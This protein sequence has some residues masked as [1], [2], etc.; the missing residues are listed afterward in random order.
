[1][2]RNHKIK[3]K[4]NTIILHIYVWTRF[5]R[6]LGGFDCRTL[7]LP[8]KWIIRSLLKVVKEKSTCQHNA[9]EISW[10]SRSLYEKN[11]RVFDGWIFVCM[12]VIAS[13]RASECVCQRAWSYAS[14]RHWLFHKRVSDE[15][16]WCKYL[17]AD[18]HAE[19][20]PLDIYPQGFAFLAHTHSA[21]VV[22]F[23]LLFPTD[24]HSKRFGPQN[25]GR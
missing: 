16:K 3:L 10:I 13:E 9:R 14:N 2:K 11:L 15:P 21:M 22:V 6:F 8:T 5:S 25:F 1:M 4:K 19:T 24:K 7:L 18:C 20:I 12:C 17:K 23:L